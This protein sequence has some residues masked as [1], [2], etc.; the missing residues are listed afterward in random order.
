MRRALQILSF[1]AVAFMSSWA[2]AAPNPPASFA[3][4]A[5]RLLPAVVNIS[6][7]QE[8]QEA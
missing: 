3:D 5:E 8:I 2:G 7:T 6:T 4:L 1:L